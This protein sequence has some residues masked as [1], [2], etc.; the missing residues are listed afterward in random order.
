[1]SNSECKRFVRQK[2]KSYRDAA[3]T[4]MSNNYHTIVIYNPKEFRDVLET[5]LALIERAKTMGCDSYRTRDTTIQFNE[6][7]DEGPGCLCT[8]PHNDM[9]GLTPER[10]RSL[11][12]LGAA[13]VL[14]RYEDSD[15]GGW[16]TIPNSL[17]EW[18]DKEVCRILNIKENDDVVI[19]N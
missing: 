16:C 4:S 17:P 7:D 14:A 15:F 6:M 10:L 19:T 13:V 1:M 3:L 9:E 5:A 18:L 2:L 11:A 12:L 8:F